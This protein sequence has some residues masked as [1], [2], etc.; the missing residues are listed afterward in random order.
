MALWNWMFRTGLAIAALGLVWTMW[1]AP[2]A[3]AYTTAHLGRSRYHRGPRVAIDRGHSNDSPADSRFLALADL[4][5]W[6]GYRVT[7]S[8]QSLVPEYLKDTQV[9]VIGNALPYPAALGRLAEALGLAGRA[10][11]A[12]EEVDAV[13]DWVRA[14]GSLLLEANVPKSGQ[15]AATLAS[16]LGLAFHDCPTPVFLPQAEPDGAVLANGWVEATSPAASQAFSLLKAPATSAGSCAAGK[17]LVLAIEFGRGRVVAI[18]AQLERNDDPHVRAGVDA[19]LFG[20]RQFVLD[21]MHWLSR[22]ED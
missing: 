1:P 21:I 14:G 18:S 16:A 19:R 2:G 17:P 6:D 15:A 11:I 8:K 9:L 7:R 12:P 22:G 5:T 13:R 20:N 3:H 4:L 10:A